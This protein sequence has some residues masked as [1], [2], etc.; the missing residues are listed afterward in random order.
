V[1]L[2]L[3]PTIDRP[4][5]GF[6]HLATDDLHLLVPLFAE[7]APDPLPLLTVG[8]RPEARQQRL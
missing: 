6:G 2:P 7:L 3:A 5:F 8:E 1:S 4:A